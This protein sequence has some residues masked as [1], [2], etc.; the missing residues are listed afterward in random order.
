MAKVSVVDNGAEALLAKLKVL[1]KPRYVQV[2]VFSDAEEP[3]HPGV[4]VKEV[5]NWVEFGIGQPERPFIRNYYDLHGKE[6]VEVAKKALLEGYSPQ[7]TLE[8]VGEY[9]VAG[10]RKFIE[11]Y[12]ED[13][14]PPNELDTINKKD[15]TV[16]VIDS[17]TLFSHIEY[18]VVD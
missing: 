15:S 9:G 16:P 4:S 6:S 13:T 12:G 5:A 11:G 10:I 18:K 3:D 8:M 1:K 17:G 2:G 7:K 14:Y